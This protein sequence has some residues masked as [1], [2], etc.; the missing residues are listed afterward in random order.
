MIFID[1]RVYLVLLSFS[2]L[3]ADVELLWSI[4]VCIC[5]SGFSASLNGGITLAILLLIHNL[6]LVYIEDYNSLCCGLV[7]NRKT[8]YSISCMTSKMVV[9]VS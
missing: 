1:E 3:G 8:V 2:G 6:R 7:T 4:R 5:C 9:A